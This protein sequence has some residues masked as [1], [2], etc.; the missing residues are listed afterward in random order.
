[1]AS[2][3]SCQ[4]HSPLASGTRQALM[5][6]RSGYFLI[7]SRQPGPSVRCRCSRL[8]LK[9]DMVSIMRLTSAIVKKWRETSSM[10]PR[11]SNC[12]T[13]LMENAGTEKP[14]SVRLAFSI[15]TALCHA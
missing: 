3:T 15:C 14:P 1:M 9:R 6:V 12:G 4:F 5:A 2:F 10:M 11:H 13:S 8:S 7:S